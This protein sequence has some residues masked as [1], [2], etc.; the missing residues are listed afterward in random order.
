MMKM[1][2][3]TP[4]DSMISVVGVGVGIIIFSLKRFALFHNI[5]ISTSGVNSF[6]P[7]D[8]MFSKDF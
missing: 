2:I 3:E 8:N 7:C 4:K 5:T 1:K 6:I